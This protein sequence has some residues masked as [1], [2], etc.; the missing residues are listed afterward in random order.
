[1]SLP[2]L[3]IRQFWLLG[4]AGQEQVEELLVHVVAHLVQDEPITVGTIVEEGLQGIKV[5]T[6]I[7]VAVHPQV[8]Q[9]KPH[10]AGLQQE[11]SFQYSDEAN[12]EEEKVPPPEDKV[13]LIINDVQ[14][15]DAEGVKSGLLPSPSILEVGTAG[16]PW[17]SL[18]HGIV[19]SESVVL[20]WGSPEVHVDVHPVREEGAPKESIGC[21]HLADQDDQIED[22]A[23]DEC[24]KISVVLVVQVLVEGGQQLIPLLLRVLHHLASCVLG[25]VLHQPALQ[26]DPEGSG[27]EEDDGLTDQAEGDPLVEGVEHVSSR[28]FATTMPR[29]TAFK[30]WG[31]VEA[32]VHPTE[33]FQG[34]CTHP[35]SREVALDG[36]S[37]KLVGRHKERRDQQ[38]TACVLVEQLEGPVVNAWLSFSNHQC[39]GSLNCSQNG[40]HASLLVF[41]SKPC[42]R[43]STTVNH[44]RLRPL[45]RRQNTSLS[46]KIMFKSLNNPKAGRNC[47]YK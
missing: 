14:G 13:N 24:L 6:V 19:P 29:T 43:T 3:P 38:K 37:K 18:A 2:D 41:W 21:Q 22:L 33:A 39:L 35:S 45:K 5:L 34:A 25:Q 11:N 31:Y 8:H 9:L 4:Q 10:P 7:E 40:R 44:Q 32:A 16:N 42:S 36:V 26:G 23:A 46:F 28:I 12:Q 17:E 1:V 30:L 15:K 27:K 47:I 20:L